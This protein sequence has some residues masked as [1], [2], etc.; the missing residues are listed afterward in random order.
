MADEILAMLENE[1]AQRY[2]VWQIYWWNSLGSSPKKHYKILSIDD[3]NLNH[4]GQVMK[5]FLDKYKT[6][7]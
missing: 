4:M 3:S 1:T 7:E 5:E 6:W 2:L